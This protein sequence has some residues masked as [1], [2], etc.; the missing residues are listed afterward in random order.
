M[1]ASLAAKPIVATDVGG[2]T[3]IVIDGETGYIVPVNDSQQL[4][5]RVKELLQDKPKAAKMGDK[6]YKRAVSLFDFEA[7]TKKLITAWE[8]MIKPHGDKG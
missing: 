1:E 3:D 6:G 4:A 2:V 7:N 8:T 5:E